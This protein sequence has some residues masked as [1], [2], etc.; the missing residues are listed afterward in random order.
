VRAHVGLEPSGTRDGGLLLREVGEQVTRGPDDDSTSI[1]QRAV[2]DVAQEHRLADA[3][4]TEQHDVLPLG[5]EAEREEVFDLR[6]V[7]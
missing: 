7:T 5:D 3:V 6:L 1:V 2:G 4:G